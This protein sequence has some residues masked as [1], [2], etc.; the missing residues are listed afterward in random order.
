MTA[1]PVVVLSGAGISAESGVPTFRGAGGLW[2]S[3]RPEDLATPAAFARDPALVWRWYDWRRGIV[4][5]CRPNAAHRVLVEMERSLVSS[6]GEGSFT[7]VTQNVDGLHEAAG[8][9][10]VLRL[11]GSIWHTRCESCGARRED[12]TVPLPDGG[13]LCSDCGQRVR[14]NIVWFGETLDATILNRAFTA[15]RAAKTVI[16]VGT[17]GLV[18][19]AAWIPLAGREAGAR[20]VVV[21]AE[22]TPLSEFADEFVEGPAAEALPAWWGRNAGGLV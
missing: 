3:Y 13:P 7:L 4:A 1:G 2:E 5:G 8:S 9:R 14:P 10:N 21:N 17:S 20:V 11:H 12:R 19:P 15:A 18:T 22:P 6:C 16:V